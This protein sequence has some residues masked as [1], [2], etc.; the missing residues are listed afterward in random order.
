MPPS[1]YS[2]ASRRHIF[3]VKV[4]DAAPPHRHADSF[5]IDSRRRLMRARAPVYRADGHDGL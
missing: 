5:D 4:S 1:C 3:A 2:R